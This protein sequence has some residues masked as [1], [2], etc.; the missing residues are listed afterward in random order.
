MRSWAVVMTPDVAASAR[1]LAAAR[2]GRAEA[3]DALN[4]SVE[5][6]R[7]WAKREGVV[8]PRSYQRRRLS[9]PEFPVAPATAANV[10]DGASPRL[11]AFLAPERAAVRRAARQAE[12][13]WLAASGLEGAAL[14]DFGVLRAHR[15]TRSDALLAIGR[16]DLAG[17]P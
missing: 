4:I 12:A 1:A 6:L 15:M 7:S 8:F 16:P 11:R 9:W 5:T 17:A 2:L 3:A 10:P 13:A 14:R